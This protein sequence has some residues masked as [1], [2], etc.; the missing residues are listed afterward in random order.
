MGEQRRQ[1]PLI[2]H[3]A[4]GL[5][6]KPYYGS[7]AD[8]SPDGASGV[9]DEVGADEQRLAGVEYHVDAGVFAQPPREL[10]H[11]VPRY[12]HRLVPPALVGQF[13]DVAVVAKRG[14]IWSA[15]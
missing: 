9:V 5:N 8:R 3:D 10:V 2:Q 13:I 12:R 7:V 11:G 6:G 1:Y 15:A 4:V 14:S